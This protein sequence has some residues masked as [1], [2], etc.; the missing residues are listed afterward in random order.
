MRVDGL[1][2]G[3]DAVLV[4]LVV[5]D[6][7][8]RD[9]AGIR[10]RGGLGHLAQGAGT[11]LVE[12]QVIGQ[13]HAERL[14]ADH[15]ACAKHR[16]AQAQR[17]GLGHE[18]RANMPRQGALDHGQQLFLALLRQL[19]LQ[20]VGLVE[21]VGDGVLVAVGDEHQGVGAGIDG[22]VDGVLDQRAVQ[23]RQHFLG[24]GL[25]RRQETRAQS[26]HREDDFAQRL[27]HAA[28]SLSVGMQRHHVTGLLRRACQRNAGSRREICS[29]HGLLVASAHRMPQLVQL[30][31]A[32]VPMPPRAIVP[33]RSW[34]AWWRCIPH[35]C[36]TAPRTASRPD[37]GR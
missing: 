35:G 13:H 16:V 20:L 10:G 29:A 32:A 26:G 14:V 33:G 28:P 30:R 6:F 23:D 7:L 3:H 24:H 22:L 15:G 1:A 17:L 12:D 5:R 8:D 36:R 18:H 34:R 9:H 4:G 21:V 31:A 37:A 27:A 19:R 25:G 2:G 11:T